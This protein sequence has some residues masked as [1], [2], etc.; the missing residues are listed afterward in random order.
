MAAAVEVLV[1]GPAPQH[2]PAV[3]GDGKEPPD[4]GPEHWPPARSTVLP[5]EHSNARTACQSSRSSRQICGTPCRFAEKSGM[6][7]NLPGT[8]CF[9]PDPSRRGWEGLP[10]AAGALGA[11]ARR[12]V[13]GPGR[14]G[15]TRPTLSDRCGCQP[16]GSAAGAGGTEGDRDGRAVSLHAPRSRGGFPGRDGNLRAARVRNVQHQVRPA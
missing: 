11:G 16:A 9:G 15:G 13:A 6:D 5:E 3:A 12:F 1:A 14:R 2:L 8:W 7:G 10:R 4:P